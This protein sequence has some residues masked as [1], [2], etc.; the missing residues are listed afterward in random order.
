MFFNS[1]T[2][3]LVPYFISNE[4]SKH[5]ASEN[6][7]DKLDWNEGAISPSPV[8]IKALHAYLESGQLNTYPDTNNTL[9]R[10]ALAEYA[11]VL[12]DNVEYFSGSDGAHLEILARCIEKGDRVLMLSPSYDNFRA[13]AQA[14]GAEI[15]HLTMD[16]DSRQ[17]MDRA[18]FVEKIH[19]VKPKL[20]YVCNPNNP[21]GHLYAEEYIEGLLQYCPNSLFLIDEAYF[22][23]AG[24][25]AVRLV[26]RYKNIIITRTFSK[27]FCLASCRIG[28][29]IGPA[30]L[31][32]RLR[33]A[34]NPKSVNAFAQIAAFAALSDIDYMRKFVRELIG[35]RH[36]F[37]NAL[38][39]LGYVVVGVQN[40]NYVLLDLAED[41]EYIIDQ[42][43]SASILIRDC[44]HIVESRDLIRITIG[45]REQMNR[46]T[47]IFQ[48]AQSGERLSGDASA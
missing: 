29:A 40:A 38:T 1:A 23:F 9:L 19:E 30:Y 20:V 42:F 34:K 37:V 13:S 16:I 24:I 35:I 31:I 46:V 12:S 27:A 47:A 45:T 21:S 32:Q 26:N 8:V 25:T 2:Q 17:G 43:Q 10:N 41:Y 7:I 6:R 44:R 5:Q 48:S 11:D 3:N 22:E 39:S 18:F 14:E 15:I 36:E 28:Y 33:E 4:K